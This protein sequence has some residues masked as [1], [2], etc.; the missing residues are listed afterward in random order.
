VKRTLTTRTTPAVTHH[1][2]SPSSLGER[3]IFLFGMV[4][5]VAGMVLGYMIRGLSPTATA[6]TASAPRQESQS[7]AGAVTQVGFNDSIAPLEAALKSN[8]KNLA[9]LIQLGNLYSDHRVLPRAIEYY[10]RALEIDPKNVKVR[11][12]LG[13]VY[14]YSGLPDKAIGEYKASLLIDPTHFETLFNLAV[15]YEDGF[16]DHA[17]AVET[18]EKLLQFYPKHPKR[19]QVEQLIESTKQ[20]AAASTD[21]GTPSALRPKN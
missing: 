4:C 8:P 9:L 2:V 11:T 10:N 7:P 17:R 12:D 18:W 15:V 21:R 14:W 13:T 6:A 1:K 19:A 3:Q 5:L 20:E 16:K